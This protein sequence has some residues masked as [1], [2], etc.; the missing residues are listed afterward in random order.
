M[1]P[2]LINIDDNSCPL[3]IPLI[4]PVTII[5]PAISL[6]TSKAFAG[7]KIIEEVEDKPFV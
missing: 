1:C 4:I 7:P 2:T 5:Y 3:N 6:Q